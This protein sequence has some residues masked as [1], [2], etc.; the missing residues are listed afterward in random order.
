MDSVPISV[1]QQ[2]EKEMNALESE[3]RRLAKLLELAKQAVGE[4]KG[5]LSAHECA[6]RQDY[7]NTNYEVVKNKVEAFYFEL[8]TV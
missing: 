5:I 2:M 7:G 6:I 4:C 1:V 8:S 3:R